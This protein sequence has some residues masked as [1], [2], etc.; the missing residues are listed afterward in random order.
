MRLAAQL[1]GFLVDV[2]EKDF[3]KRL[4]IFIPL[5]L[6]CLDREHRHDNDDVMEEELEPSVVS[7]TDHLLFNTL[8]T[9]EKIFTV[10][11]INGGKGQ[12]NEQYDQI[13]GMCI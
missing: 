12:L 1:V 10:C 2:E 9:I 4:V 5:L 11:G 13:W 8:V 7:L 3:E 6:K